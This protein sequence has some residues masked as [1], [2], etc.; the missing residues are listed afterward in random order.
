MSQLLEILGRAITVDTADLI[1]HWLNVVGF[2]A[3]NSESPRYQQMHKTMELMS[4]MKLD[5]ATEHLRMYLFEY[6]SCT[7][8]RLAAAAIC[9]RNN[10]LPEAIKE[11]NSV[12]LRQP[13]NTMALYALGHCYERLGKESQAVEF[14]QDCLKFKNYLQLPAQRLAA[15]YFKNGQLEKTTQQY[16][17]LKSE[18]PD[19]IS[20]LVTLGH[21]YI[22]TGRYS[23]AVET[24]NTA[25]LIHPD[26]FQAH[27]E[28]ID[29]L[30]AEGQVYEALE[31]IEDLIQAQPDKP[32]LLMRYADILRMIGATAEAISQ[33]EQ[34]L[35]VC[36]DFLEATIKLGTQYLQMEQ[37]HLAAQQFNR[38]TQI[39]DNIV[40]AYIGLA[41][42]QKSSGNTSDALGT[43]SLA[44]AIQPNSSLL[45]NETATLRFKAGLKENMPY[46]HEEDYNSL[47]EAVI[48][49]HRLQINLHPQNPD[50]HYRLGILMINAGRLVEA[51]ESFQTALEIN[52]AY[53]RAKSKLA[54]S[55]LEANRKTDALNQLT[56][57]DCLDKDT[58]Q[59]HYQTAMLYCDRVKFASSLINLEHHLE[60]N[61]ASPDAT[62]NISIILQ[63]LGLLDRATAM[64][65]NLTDIANQ[66]VGTD[67][68]F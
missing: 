44:A 55:L 39:N 6:P 2:P 67:N 54:V 46:G 45:F 50:L 59:L 51:I 24:F 36:P 34:A 25:I 61:Y 30:I 42:A 27:D 8:G 60:S 64:W 7:H 53:T 21:L 3:E 56:S 43:L 4:E 29:R 23:Q 11:L 19:D 58:L 66:A 13:N 40:E 35:R 9:L 26:N 10:Q 20:M 12:Y 28:N 1:W 52:P 31:H 65:D 14:Y 18:Y 37:E 22:V 38:A 49:A 33:Y 62:V 47:T 5:A 17:L 63:N 32:D 68:Q 48:V 16:E 41:I 15:I 57:S